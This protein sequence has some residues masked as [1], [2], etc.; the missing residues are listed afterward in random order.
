MNYNPISA[1]S[2]IEVRSQNIV[3]YKE[4]GLP[5]SGVID[6]ALRVRDVAS[7]SSRRKHAGGM[8]WDIKITMMLS[9]AH[10]LFLPKISRALG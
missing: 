8:E 10:G 6:S 1:I 2:Y 9:Y 3:A 4:Q 7:T 5:G